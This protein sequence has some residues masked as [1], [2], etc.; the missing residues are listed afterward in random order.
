MVF[1]CNRRIRIPGNIRTVPKPKIPNAPRTPNR[2]PKKHARPHPQAPPPIA[3]PTA[4]Q[5]THPHRKSPSQ[6]PASLPPYSAQSA[7]ILIAFDQY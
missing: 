5:Y 4:K 3:T 2:P 6:I 1:L 7:K